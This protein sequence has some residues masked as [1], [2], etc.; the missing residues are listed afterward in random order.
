M[1]EVYD[2]SVSISPI[3]VHLRL[4]EAWLRRGMVGAEEIA[5][6]SGALITTTGG[7]CDICGD[8]VVLFA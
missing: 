6:L 2:E 7:C 5:G 4:C 1:K 8:G 3:T